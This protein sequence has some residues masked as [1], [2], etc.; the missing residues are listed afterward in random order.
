MNKL[1]VRTLLLLICFA[2]LIPAAIFADQLF[3]PISD[4]LSSPSSFEGKFV[5]VSGFYSGWKN[6]PGSPPVSRSDWVLCDERKN[7]IYC[8]GKIPQNTETGAP[9]V[10]WQ[11]LTVLA[12]LMMSEDGQPYLEIAELKAIKRSVE[13]MVSVAQ[14]LFSPIEMQGRYV[15]LTGVLAK[16]YGVKGERLYLL[17]DPTGAINLGRLPKLY[18]KGTILHI[19][20]N[21]TTDEN[22]LPMIDGVEI[23]SVKLD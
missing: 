13:E 12:R 4:L 6:A 10:F 18:P 20:G 11:P 19:R 3:T 14:I 5:T 21:V 23:V 22:G 9:E 8:T 17:A 1:F 15:G 7:A 2:S 16:G